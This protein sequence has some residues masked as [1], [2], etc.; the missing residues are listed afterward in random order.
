[1]AKHAAQLDP[2]TRHQH[3]STLAPLTLPDL[4]LVFHTSGRSIGLRH[5]HHHDTPEAYSQTACDQ[6]RA[7]EFLPTP[8]RHFD[9][10][11]SPAV[12][13][14]RVKHVLHTKV[15][16]VASTAFDGLEF[17]CSTPQVMTPSQATTLAAA[18][19]LPTYATTPEGL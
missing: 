14:T 12:I 18:L 3:Y 11:P 10:T 16:E 19:P 17:L 13:C 7:L 9:A 8:L 4:T 2:N 6:M 1:M 5:P 15:F